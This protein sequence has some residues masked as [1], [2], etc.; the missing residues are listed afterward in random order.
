MKTFYVALTTLGLVLGLSFNSQAEEKKPAPGKAVKAVAEKAPKALKAAAKIKATDTAKAKVA[1]KAPK[2]GVYKVSVA[3]EVI[4]KAK[5]TRA[6]GFA[7]IPK[8]IKGTIVL[9]ADDGT[10]LQVEDGQ[11]GSCDPPCDENQYCLRRQCI[12]ET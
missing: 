1:K 3:K 10:T 9:E 4:G 11:E 12:D 7:G 8:D 5:Y 2:E 6:Q